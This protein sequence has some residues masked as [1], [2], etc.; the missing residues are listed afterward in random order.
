MQSRI[1]GPGSVP[2][3]ASEPDA[4]RWAGVVSGR[5]ADERMFRAP[6]RV[7]RNLEVSCQ[8]RSTG[9]PM[10]KGR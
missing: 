1:S 4:L 6:R 9:K 8:P 3:G 5:R 2:A 10:E 7:K